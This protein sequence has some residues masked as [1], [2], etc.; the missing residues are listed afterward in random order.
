MS[1]EEWQQR[2]LSLCHP[3]SF[4]AEGALYL[5]S[6][7][8]VIS[9][10]TTPAAHFQAGLALDGLTAGLHWDHNS[11]HHHDGGVERL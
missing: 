10:A 9:L 5:V 6:L 11:R 4:I 7:V 1:T 8:F 2:N 3:Y